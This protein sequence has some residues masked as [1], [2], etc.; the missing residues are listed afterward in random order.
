MKSFICQGVDTLNVSDS[1]DE[2]HFAY[3]LDEVAVFQEL[4]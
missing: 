1:I 2:R 3:Q 4:V